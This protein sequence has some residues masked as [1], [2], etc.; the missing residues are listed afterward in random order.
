MKPARQLVSH[1]AVRRYFICR[2]MPRFY[3]DTHRRRD[4][5][6]TGIAAVKPI[7]A[8]LFYGVRLQAITS[9]F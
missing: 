3:Q 8:R 2:A 9:R 6:F 7:D 4:R 1:D 5:R